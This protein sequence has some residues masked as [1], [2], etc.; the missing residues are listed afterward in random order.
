[1]YLEPTLRQILVNKRK[2]EFIRNFENELYI[3]VA[4][5]AKE[6]E[7]YVQN[8]IFSFNIV[9]SVIIVSSVNQCFML[10]FKIHQN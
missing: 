9:F 6:L 7:I 5:P 1:M 4:I 2:L 3:R 8:D 10:K